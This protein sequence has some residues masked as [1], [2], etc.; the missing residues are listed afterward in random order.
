MA[1]LGALAE[2]LHRIEHKLD[3]VLEGL[4]RS[5][6]TTSVRSVGDPEH[7]CPLC[8][9]PVKYTSDMMS[10]HT[11]RQCG[12]GT[13]VITAQFSFGPTTTPGDPVKGTDDD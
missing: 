12:C 11:V 10:G 4:A 1:K 3:L 7:C 2:Q 5:N 6:P 13:G 8:F 9:N